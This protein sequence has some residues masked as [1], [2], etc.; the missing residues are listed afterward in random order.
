MPRPSASF[1][2][3]RTLLAIVALTL[4]APGGAKA[5][6]APG[7]S[8]SA[9]RAAGASEIQDIFI[10]APEG[11]PDGQ[12]LQVLIALH[13]MGGKGADFGEA[14]AS[15]ADA[16]GWLIVAPTISYGDWTDPD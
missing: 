12:P 14:L 10:R 3:L 16:H 5:L 15:Q 7:P 1:K 11:A 6:A 4:V 8:I 9:L 2:A 13:G